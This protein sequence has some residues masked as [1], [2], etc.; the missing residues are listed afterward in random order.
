MTC[1]LVGKKKSNCAQREIEFF[2]EISLPLVDC[3]EE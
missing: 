2:W 1:P 3:D